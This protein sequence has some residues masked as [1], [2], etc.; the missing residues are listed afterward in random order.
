VVGVGVGN[1]DGIELGAGEGFNDGDRV[2]IVV[3]GTE[4]N[5]LGPGVGLLLGGI[6]SMQYI[7]TN[8]VSFLRCKLWPQ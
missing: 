5:G 1:M 8:I 3:G 4:G 6:V 7:F 2:G